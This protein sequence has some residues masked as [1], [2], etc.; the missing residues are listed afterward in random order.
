[1]HTIIKVSWIKRYVKLN[2]FPTDE[3][4]Y[5]VLNDTYRIK[6]V[7]ENTK[8][9]TI[10][11]VWYFVCPVTSKRCRKLHLVDG[12]YLHAT[13]IKGYYRAN[14]PMWYSE[15]PINKILVTKQKAIDAENLIDSK[16]FKSHYADKPTKKYL[17]CLTR[18]E[19]AAHISM[20]DIINGYYD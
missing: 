7:Y 8:G 4:C 13:A 6:L 12:T 14:K 18:I 17:K 2:P 16:H 9:A 1:M 10:G 15:K 19:A 20:H 5:V 3:C 11:T